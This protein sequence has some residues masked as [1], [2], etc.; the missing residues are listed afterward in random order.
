MDEKCASET[1]LIGV[2]YDITRNGV[3]HGQVSGTY[4]TYFLEFTRTLIPADYSIDIWVETTNC[5][6][7]H[8]VIDAKLLSE[9]NGT[10]TMANNGTGP[11][12]V[13]LLNPFRE[14]RI[15]LDDFWTDAVSDPI[16]VHDD[17][18]LLFNFTK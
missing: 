9:A 13:T 16:E 10:L 12:I 3:T 1:D 2:H 8:D 4:I 7:E 17:K 15:Y 6:F 14:K 5:M 11:C 18:E